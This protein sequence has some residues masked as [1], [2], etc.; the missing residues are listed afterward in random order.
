M[1]NTL[2][3]VNGHKITPLSIDGFSAPKA[4]EQTR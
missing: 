4:V 3:G 1:I 2:R